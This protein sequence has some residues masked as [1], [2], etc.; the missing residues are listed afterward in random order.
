[1]ALFLFEIG[2]ERENVAT[3]P[4]VESKATPTAAKPEK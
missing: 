1:M 4:V 2:P 3:Q